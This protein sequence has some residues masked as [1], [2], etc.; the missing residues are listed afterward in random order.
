M[1]S[2]VLKNKSLIL[3]CLLIFNFSVPISIKKQIDEKTKDAAVYKGIIKESVVSM[4]ED[5]VSKDDK[6][7][8]SYGFTKNILVA[9]MPFLHLKET[10][11]EEVKIKNND[12]MEDKE[13]KELTLAKK[14][15]NAVSTVGGKISD[16]PL[17]LIYHTHA[18]ESFKDKT[19]KGTYRSRNNDENMV[20]VGREV[21]KVLKNEYGIE[22]VH[23]TS[24]HDYP[25]YNAAY[26]NSLKSAEKI[27]KKNPGIKYVFDI[28]R[29]GLPSSSDN[30]KYKGKVGNT[31][32]SNVMIVLGMNHKNSSKNLKFA[33]KID[34]QFDKMYPSISLGVTKREPYR[35]NQ[36]L[37]SNS[38]LFEVGS[39][40][41][42]L[43]ESKNSGKLIGRV[44]GEVI[45]KD[46]KGK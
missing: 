44:I 26:D 7:G 10:G 17:V 33:N 45:K 1:L 18:T 21:V 14:K 38:I 8:S 37:S 27:L 41:N 24:Q 29:D 2:G 9:S 43:E 3:I 13:S 34:A 35:Y 16:K 32:V 12:K 28:H 6:K 23:D 25:S 42:T 15:M 31:K 19:T 46:M 5:T 20:S 39:N 4:N 30:L 11:Y 40:L 22:A 36:W